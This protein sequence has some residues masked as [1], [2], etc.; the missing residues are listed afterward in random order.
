MGSLFYFVMPGTSL[1]ILINPILCPKYSRPQMHF[2]SRLLTEME[3]V[4]DWSDA[5][6]GKPFISGPGFTA[7]SLG[8]LGYVDVRKSQFLHLQNG[9]SITSFQNTLWQWTTTPF[10][11]LCVELVTQGTLLGLFIFFQRL[12]FILPVSVEDPKEKAI[13]QLSFHLN[14][15]FYFKITSSKSS[16]APT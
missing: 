6:W 15:V 10:Q 2:C 1:L 3:T 7:C 16:A 8:D 14:M 13:T 5:V 9:L 12:A 11:M 4:G